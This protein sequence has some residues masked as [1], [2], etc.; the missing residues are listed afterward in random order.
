M[1]NSSAVGRFFV[2][3]RDERFTT[4]FAI[5][6]RRF[7]TNTV[8]K[9]PLAQ[10]MRVLG[11]NGE[12]NTLQGNLNWWAGGRGLEGP[13]RR[14]RVREGRRAL[15]RACVAGQ[16]PAGQP[17]SQAAAPPCPAPPVLPAAP[18]PP[19][20]ATHAAP[21]PRLCTCR[22]AS[23]QAGLRNE[24]WRGREHDFLPLCSARGGLLRPAPPRPAQPR[25]AR[26]SRPWQPRPPSCRPLHPPPSH[27]PPSHLPSPS[28]T[29]SNPPPS[30]AE[31]DSANLDHMAELMVRSGTD[32]QEAL[33]ALVPEAYRNHPDLVKNYPEVGC[34]GCGWVV[35]RVCAGCGALGVGVLGVGVL[36]WG[37]RRRWLRAWQRVPGMPATPSTLLPL[38]RRAPHLFAPPPL[39]PA[40]PPPLRCPQVIDFYEYYE[41]LQEG[42]DGPALLVFSDGI[43]VG[44]RLDRNGLRPARFWQVGRV[45]GGG[46]GEQAGW[47]QQTGAWRCEGSAQG[48]AAAP[49]R[50]ARGCAQDRAA[51]PRA[52]LNL[53]CACPHLTWCHAPHPPH[54]NPHTPHHTTPSTHTP[55]LPPCRRPPTTWCMWPPRWA[56]WAMC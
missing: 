24:V 51:P 55:P 22:V 12:I 48:G 40:L 3:L 4:P 6:H 16:S 41:G 35:C 18:V 28:P 32:P 56:C 11:H 45:G 47:R 13:D 52:C 54:N 2:D 9:W 33:M 49:A 10:P 20:Q 44:A 29:P 42:W 53:T 34:G 30:P 26:P 50:P 15:H 27:L 38:S 14:R 43:K 31:S 1:L 25:P 23:R 21:P 39:P 36:C 8:P 7:S 19:S 37:R 5:Y 46:V 17:G